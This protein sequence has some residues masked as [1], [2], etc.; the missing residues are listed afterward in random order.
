MRRAKPSEVERV[1][2]PDV[3]SDEHYPARVTS[4]VHC[5][6]YGKGFVRCVCHERK[7]ERKHEVV[8]DARRRA[9][10]KR[11]YHLRC[12]QPYIG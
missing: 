9:R 7:R 5:T 2:P 12:K 10:E 11:G 3:I 6:V 1:S 8:R 4:C